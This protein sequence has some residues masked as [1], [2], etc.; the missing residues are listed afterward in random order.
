ME[1][2]SLA[3]EADLILICPATANIMAKVASG[4]A[5]DLLT[6]TILATNAPVVFAPAM[7]V[8][9]WKNRAT[10]ENIEKLKKL[11]YYIIDPEYGDLACGYKGVGR[12]A[13][14][15]KILSVVSDLLA[16]GSQLAGKKVI[17]TS[18]ATQEQLDAVRVITNKASGKMG[19]ALA[20]EAFLRGAKVVLIRSQQAVSPQYFVEE[21]AVET[22]IPP[23][24]P[25]LYPK[26]KLTERLKAPKSGCWRLLQISKL[27]TG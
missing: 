20:D 15:G 11:G 6:T 8:K 24:F 17:V 21:I 9:M 12:L 27:L 26:K 10:Q 2:I 1:H 22:V 14:G 25:I 13:K 5:D 3:D 23:P 18:G 16:K 4:L 7:N 19:A